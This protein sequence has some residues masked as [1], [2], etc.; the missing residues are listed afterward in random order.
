MFEAVLL[1][2]GGSLGWCVGVLGPFIFCCMY[3]RK[4]ER[5]RDGKDNWRKEKGGERDRKEHWREG[6]ECEWQIM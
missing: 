4:K 6:K 3:T 5:E 1:K 2:R